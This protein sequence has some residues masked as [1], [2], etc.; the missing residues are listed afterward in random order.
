[1]NNSI[2]NDTILTNI[3]NITN[4]D[5]DDGVKNPE[6]RHILSI[7]ITVII[8]IVLI[9][10]VGLILRLVIVESFCPERVRPSNIVNFDIY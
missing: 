2:F 1:M 8:S 9:A 10:I 3:T 4:I 6:L 7:V 5:E